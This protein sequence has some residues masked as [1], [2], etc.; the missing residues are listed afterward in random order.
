MAVDDYID[1]DID[2][3]GF[4]V[5]EW[6]DGLGCLLL[7]PP[8]PLP[9]ARADQ[10]AQAVGGAPETRPAQ[11]AAT[12]SPPRCHCCHHCHCCR[13]EAEPILVLTRREGAGFVLTRDHS[14]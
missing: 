6:H 8:E 2:I 14:N 4:I 11:R 1:I 7:E 12:S 9:L 3:F 13:C 5:K 10:R